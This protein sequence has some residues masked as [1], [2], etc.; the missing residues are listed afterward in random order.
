MNKNR[1]AERLSWVSKGVMEVNNARYGCF[2]DNISNEGALIR[3][4]DTNVP[5]L[6]LGAVCMLK[7]I[8]LNVTEYPCKVVRVNYPQVGL[9]FLLK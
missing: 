9:L 8:L 7:V 6:K 5:S 1:H 2:L 3:F 4:S